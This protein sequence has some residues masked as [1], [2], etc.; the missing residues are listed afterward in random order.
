MFLDSLIT[1]H[2]MPILKGIKNKNGKKSNIPCLGEESAISKQVFHVCLW[3]SHDRHTISQ[4]CKYCL[5]VALWILHLQVSLV[6][7]Q[8]VS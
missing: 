2:M 8:V 1:I 3:L 6:I 4:N 7:F 5:V